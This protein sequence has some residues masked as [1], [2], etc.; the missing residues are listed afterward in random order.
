MLDI[1]SS[2]ATIA[3]LEAARTGSM[4]AAAIE[5]GVTHGA[6]SRR[7]G[8]VEHWLGAPIFERIGRGVRLTPQG[9]IFVRRAERSLASL[10]ALRSELSTQRS[11]GSVR[12]SALPSVARL[13]VM[14]HLARLEVATGHDLVD[15]VAEHR[16]ARLDDREADLAIRYGSGGWPG[17]SSRLLFHDR[18]LP[19]A[20][21]AIAR[22]LAGCEA[23]DLLRETLIVDGDGADWRR[24]CRTAGLSYVEAGPRRRYIDYDLG[25][26]AARQGLGVVLLRLPLASH[27]VADGSLSP[28]PL[29]QFISERGHHLVS[30]PNEGNPR[31]LALAEALVAL[32]ADGLAMASSRSGCET[33]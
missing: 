15:V 17:L 31:V 12:L 20:S 23:A 9:Q 14:P 2:D 3:V 18:I 4:S 30:R 1:P 22:A 33:S 21:P 27:A 10:A 19:A 25:I 6:I 29:P 26:E 11:R 28:L 32:S 13:W 24:W 5:L 8:L 7:I 16:L